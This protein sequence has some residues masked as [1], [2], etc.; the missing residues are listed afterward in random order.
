MLELEEAE[1]NLNVVQ[2]LDAHA[3]DTGWT[4][5]DPIGNGWDLP[6][7]ASQRKRLS[8]RCIKMRK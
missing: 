6:L 7:S 8:K 2:P 1:Q 3:S 5:S 4:T